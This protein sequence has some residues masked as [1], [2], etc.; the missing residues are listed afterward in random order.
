MQIGRTPSVKLV[1]YE[2]ANQ[3][4]NAN[5]R[6]CIAGGLQVAVDGPAKPTVTCH[7]NKDGTV[8]VTWVPPAA[9]EYHIHIKIGGKEVV[10]SPFLARVAGNFIA[11]LT[12]LPS[13]YKFRSKR[14][15]LTHVGRFDERGADQISGCRYQGSQCVD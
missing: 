5:K 12:L 3:I 4:P 2:C 7:D 13:V 11:C 8:S 10:N 6:W 15:A 1:S 14:E 9:G